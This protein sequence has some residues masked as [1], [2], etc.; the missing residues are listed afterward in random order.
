M[1]KEIE[2]YEGT[3]LEFPP[4]TPDEVIDRVARE[5]TERIKGSETAAMRKDK[6]SYEKPARTE[7]DPEAE[8]Q[9][10]GGDLKRERAKPTPQG[11]QP[12]KPTTAGGGR[13]NV[14]P[15]RIGEGRREGE[16]VLDMAQRPEN[17]A[18]TS[19][20]E[21]PEGDARRRQVLVR[22][23]IEPETL[24]RQ[25]RLAAPMRGTGVASA[26]PLG[27]VLG[28]RARMGLERTVGKG[29]AAIVGGVGSGLA[30][31][32][33]AGTGLVTAGADLV[34]ADGV[35]EFAQGATNQASGFQQAVTPQGEGIDKTIS[36]VFSSITASVPFMVT[37]T[38]AEKAAFKMMFTQ[39][40]FANYGESRAA[41]F[42][43][44]PSAISATI[45]GLAE[46]AGEKFGFPEQTIAVK[47]LMQRM[48]S[49]GRSSDD[50]AKNAAKLLIKE[51]PGEQLT[52]LIQFLNDKYGF[53]ARS[54]EATLTDYFKQV[55][56]TLVT[57]MG[58]STV[59]GGAPAAID[60]TRK[61]YAD[62]DAAIERSA[63][64]RGPYKDAADRGL[65]VDPPLTTDAPT[66]Q[67]AKTVRIFED[68]AAQHGIPANVVKRAKEAA[69][70]MPAAEVGPFLNDML[71]VLQRKGAIPR[72][73]PK[74]DA[75]LLSAGPMEPVIEPK[76][77]KTG[78]K[79]AE[80]GSEPA[81]SESEDLTGLAEETPGSALEEAAHQAATSPKND[82]PEPTNAQKEAGN[83]KMGHARVAGMDMSIENPVDSV[84]VD[85][86]NDPPKWKNKM[87]GAHYGYARGS[88]GMDGEAI[89]VFAKPGTSED[90]KGPVFVID[91]VHADGTPD[92]HKIMAG[93]DSLEEA[94]D[95][96]LAH[97]PKGWKGIGAITEASREEFDAWRTT[98][99]T[100]KPF[101]RNE[102]PA[103]PDVQPAPISPASA[104][105]A[106]DHQPGGSSGAVGP[107]ADDATGV[108]S[109]DTA[110]P[111][112]NVQAPADVGRGL[113]GPDPLTR[114]VARVGSTPSAAEDL[115]LRPNKDGT[116]TPVM[117]KH[118]ILDFESGD[119]L[120]LPAGATDQ[121]VVDAIKAAK[122]F[123]KNT[124]YYGVNGQSFAASKGKAKP[125]AAPAPT[126]AGTPATPA[127]STAQ[128][129]ATPEPAPIQAASP[130]DATPAATPAA[131]TLESLTA[132]WRA[133]VD[134]K[135]E[136]AIRAVNAKIVAKKAEIKAATPDKAFLVPRRAGVDGVQWT[137][138]T[139]APEVAKPAAAPAQS[140]APQAAPAPAIGETRAL[141][142]EVAHFATMAEN[143]MS[144][145]DPRRKPL[146][147][148]GVAMAAGKESEALALLGTAADAAQKWGQAGMAEGLRQLVAKHTPPLTD[149]AAFV[150]D[151]AAF[152]GKTVEQPV[153]VAETGTTAQLR[154]DAAKAMRALDARTKALEALKDCMEKQ[155]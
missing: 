77:A 88:K 126:P 142:G 80:T 145:K 140:P 113:G 71:G 60:A 94:R 91:Q 32:G 57:T 93:Y 72:P 59:V 111:E 14:D 51:V 25:E 100:T 12:L 54:P 98:G 123:G 136:A 10:V 22:E 110:A 23:S 37:G 21:T 65:N 130:V 35:S 128:P 81:A 41:N 44:L 153:L 4:D 47:G 154:M 48:L 18:A 146:M 96:Y 87:V 144:I 62:A 61:T 15:P 97:Y 45:T 112:P 40:A 139:V 86:K 53:A 92:E 8:Q 134:A 138:E 20:A 90:H 33:K 64:L 31:L 115:V 118:E 95:T 109:G 74:K 17:V 30:E 120:K 125:E 11:L 150:G 34:G 147:M 83:Y 52:T 121:E 79:P 141:A 143:E 28:D 43:P 108:R 7:A 106:G 70:G 29:G 76:E 84:R 129:P 102:Q 116:V 122:A 99:D 42:D 67:R 137:T 132:E 36:D 58:Q 2:L 85:T 149:A 38:A 68:L 105:A 19:F 1:T 103:Q 82:L 69:D 148:A 101:A 104:P 49:Q 119:P 27:Q 56:H 24:A 39:T 135:D 13:G 63:T 89:D 117:G 124:R 5:E 75:D 114:V 152:E 107:V 50:M 78:T 26:T 131:E 9:S 55:G 66:K 6:A 46:V 16:S 155:R 3:T 133:A 73:I 151:Y 127:E